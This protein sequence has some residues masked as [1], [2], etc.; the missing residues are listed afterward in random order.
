MRRY[1]RKTEDA[2]GAAGHEVASYTYPSAAYWSFEEDRPAHHDA[3]EPARLAL[4]RTV[5]FL[6]TRIGPTK[7]SYSLA[8]LSVAAGVPSPWGVT[9]L[10]TRGVP[11]TRIL[12]TSV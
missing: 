1:E 6:R 10:F 8:L 7:H 12:R 11:G 2:L 5:G 3:E 4:E 9:D